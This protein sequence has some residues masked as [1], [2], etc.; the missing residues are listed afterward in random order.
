MIGGLP[1]KRGPRVFFICT[2]AGRVERGPRYVNA[3]PVFPIAL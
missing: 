1:S 2:K 3:P